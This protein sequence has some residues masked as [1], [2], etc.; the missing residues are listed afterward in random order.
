M[1]RATMS[2]KSAKPSTDLFAASDLATLLAELEGSFPA[3]KAEAAYA[4]PPAGLFREM[5]LLHLPPVARH[6]LVA[7]GRLLWR[8]FQELEKNEAGHKVVDLAAPLPLALRALASEAR[9]A[10]D[11]LAT[12]RGVHRLT[13][14]GPGQAAF[15]QLAGRSL[16]KLQSLSREI[17]SQLPLLLVAVEVKNEKSS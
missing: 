4:G 11:W 8:Y 7:L 16:R 10:A 3:L 13:R 1:F 14:R 6:T 15:G 5:D 2:T 12:T 17:D 9:Y